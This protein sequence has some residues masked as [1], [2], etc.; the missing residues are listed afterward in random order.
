[1]ADHLDDVVMFS[2]YHV[3][4]TLQVTLNTCY[5]RQTISV[6]LLCLRL[7]WFKKSISE[8]LLKLGTNLWPGI[9]GECVSHSA[10]VL[11]PPTGWKGI[12]TKQFYHTTHFVFHLYCAPSLE[13]PIRA[14]RCCSINQHEWNLIPLIITER[15]AVGYQYLQISIVR[16]DIDFCNKSL[17][18]NESACRRVWVNGWVVAALL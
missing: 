1:M 18:K 2:C 12:S 15:P 9:A 13:C 8:I 5:V 10:T 17:Q 6:S 3:C 14:V 7:F 16:L 11:M 4:L